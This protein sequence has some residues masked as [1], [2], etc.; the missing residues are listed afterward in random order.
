LV[1]KDQLNREVKIKNFPPKRI[2]S[3]VPSQSELLAELKLDDQVI[4]ITKFCIHPKKWWKNKTRVGGTKNYNIDLINQLNPDLIIANKEENS[5]E[6]LLLLNDKYPVF[7]S[8]VRDYSSALNMIKL[9]GEITNRKSISQNIVSNINHSFK[10]VFSDKV[11]IKKVAYLIWNNPIMT[12]NSDTFISDI[13]GLNGWQNVFNHYDDRYPEIN[14]DILKK[15]A[16]DLIFLSSEPFPFSEKHISFFKEHIPDSKV[17]LVNGE[18]FSWYGSR[19]LLAANYLNK[20]KK[21]LLLD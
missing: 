3:L 1:I 6:S 15:A 5:K 9:I 18:F 13:L 2:I 8:D 14:I 10:T 21:E 17:V 20:L 11:R 4:G 16:P 12:I 7:I 19:L